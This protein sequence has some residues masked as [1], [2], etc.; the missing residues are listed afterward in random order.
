[1][2]ATETIYTIRAG[3]SATVLIT[4]KSPTREVNW[5]KVFGRLNGVYP[6]AAF[7]KTVKATYWIHTPSL[8]SS[9]HILRK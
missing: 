1:M 5:A 8:F 3:H 4:A 7:H 9:G 2:H 6:S